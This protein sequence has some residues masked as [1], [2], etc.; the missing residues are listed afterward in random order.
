LTEMSDIVKYR[1][2]PNQ[3]THLCRPNGTFGPA[4]DNNNI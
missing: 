2:N 4:R 3:K 1:Q